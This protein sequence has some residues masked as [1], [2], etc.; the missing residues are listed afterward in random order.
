MKSRVRHFSASEPQPDA[1]D[2]GGVHIH[3]GIERTQV[4]DR[5]LSHTI[6]RDT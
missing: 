5:N 2:E 1:D 6:T 4:A 3:A